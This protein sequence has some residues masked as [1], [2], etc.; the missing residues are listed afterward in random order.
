MSYSKAPSEKDASSVAV[1]NVSH[2]VW[3]WSHPT[4]RASSEGSKECS[5]G[6]GWHSSLDSPST[7]SCAIYTKHIKKVKAQCREAVL[8][9]CKSQWMAKSINQSNNRQINQS[10]NRSVSHSFSQSVSQSVS[11]V[12]NQSFN[13]WMDGSINHLIFNRK[14]QKVLSGSLISGA[15]FY[16]VL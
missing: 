5:S 14:S 4:S 1:S 15:W 10:I 7:W 8:V 6:P 16:I 9:G 3:S 13:H 11:Q 2:P 12:V